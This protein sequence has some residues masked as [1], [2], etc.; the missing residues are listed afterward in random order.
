MWQG[1]HAVMV[2]GY[3]ADLYGTQDLTPTPVVRATH[4]HRDFLRAEQHPVGI[5]WLGRALIAE[6][7]M[8]GK[9]PLEVSENL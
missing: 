1:D 3:F 9:E 5:E 2:S 6:L 4:V 7:D 8:V